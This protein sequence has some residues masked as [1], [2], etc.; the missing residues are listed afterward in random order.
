MFWVNTKRILKSGF[1]NFFRNGFVSLAAILVMS[2]TLFAVGSLLFSGALLEDSLNELK[3]KV[4]VNVYFLV[5]APEEEILR[6][7]DAV[8]GLPEVLS[9][10]YTSEEE[11]LSRFRERHADDQLTLQALDELDENPLGGSLSIRAKET[12]QYEGIANFLQGDSA[13]SIS[14]TP[15]ID[16]VN[17]NQNKDAIDKLTEIIDSS[18]RSNLMKT[19]MLVVVSVLITFNTIRLAIYNSREEIR[20]MK[21]VG[22]GNWYVQG[23]F[24]VGGAMYGIFSSAIALLL[25]Y[26]VTQWLGPIFYPFNF[27]SNVEN[28]NLLSYY[29]SNF[30]EIFITT[31]GVGILLGI[32]S[33]YLA[34]KRYINV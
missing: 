1:V 34:V 21:L 12:S 24:V 30:T 2:I 22:A 7:Q 18:E 27:F 8:E 6:V 15:I 3:D 13:L 14:E 31:V 33:S 10:T 4:D 29:S 17:Y 28:I 11:A 32:L 19:I 25:F 16:K 20:V 9:V 23:P 5:D 26:P